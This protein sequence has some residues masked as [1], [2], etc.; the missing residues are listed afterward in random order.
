MET[1][2]ELMAGT[3]FGHK[4]LVS[5]GFDM[6]RLILEYPIFTSQYSSTTLYQFFFKTIH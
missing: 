3:S 4:S 2:F 5:L 1:I 6:Y